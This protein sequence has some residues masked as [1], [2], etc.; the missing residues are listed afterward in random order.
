MCLWK[1]LTRPGSRAVG[2]Q[3]RTDSGRGQDAKIFLSLIFRGWQ[4]MSRVI[5]PVF[6]C[7]FFISANLKVGRK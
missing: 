7:F 6:F 2:S 3:R 4:H 1:A 5:F